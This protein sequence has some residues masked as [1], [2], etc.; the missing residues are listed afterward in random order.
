[1]RAVVETPPRPEAVSQAWASGRFDVIQR[2]VGALV[3]EFPHTL[4]AF[5]DG[6]VLDAFERSA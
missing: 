3:L 4:N 5:V 2:G 6:F 1:M